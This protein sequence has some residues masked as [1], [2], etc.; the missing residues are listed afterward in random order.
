MPTEVGAMISLRP[1]YLAADHVGD[2]A[3]RRH[4]R[5]RP[6]R[7]QPPVTQ[8]GDRIG[9]LEH[10]LHPVADEKDGDA[11][12]AQVAHEAEQLRHLIGGERGRRLVHD[13]HAHIERDR[14]GDLDRLLRRESEPAR[15]AAHVQSDAERREDL[16]RL[17]EH[18]PPGGDGAAALMADEDVLRHVE[19]GKEQRLLVDRGDAVALRLRCAADRDRL[20]GDQDLAF[21][22]LI[23][24]GHDLDQGG[25]AGAV[26]AQERERAGSGPPRPAPGWRR[27]A[28]RCRASPA[29]AARPNAPRLPS[30]PPSPFPHPAPA[31]CAALRS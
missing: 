7:D 22:R 10:L 11:L 24:A 31:R 3:L 21:V 15:P 23:D 8:H 13:Q 4:L 26:L 28:W 5:A 16:L 29:P 25:L 14:L 9:D 2:R 30:D 20:A 1:G 6:H 18:P 12:A 19:V 17:A 27:T